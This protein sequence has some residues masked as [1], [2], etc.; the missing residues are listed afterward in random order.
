MTR[1]LSFVF[2]GLNERVG[3]ATWGQRHIWPVLDRHPGDRRRFVMRRVWAVPTGA[4]AALVV[5]ALRTLVCRHE[6]LRTMIT[7]QDG[8]LVQHVRA[9]G[10]FEILVEE[11][12]GAWT[13]RDVTA[14]TDLIAKEEFSLDKEYPVRFLILT[15]RDAPQWVVVGASHMAV[16]GDACDILEREF[17]DLVQR[18]GGDAEADGAVTQT[19]LSRADSEQSDM[20]SKWNDRSLAYW[21]K[22]LEEF[23]DELFP[24][25]EPDENSWPDRG[26]RF[27]MLAAHAVGAGEE[28]DRKARKLRTSASNVCMAALVRSLARHSG[29][30][31]FPLGVTYSNRYLPQAEGYVGTLAQQGIIGVPD[32]LGKTFPRLSAEL[33]TSLMNGHRHAYYDQSDVDTLIART[34]ADG[35]Y[36]GYGPVAHF[37][38]FRMEQKLGKIH[39]AAVEQSSHGITL[40]ETGSLD[41]SPSRFGVY[42]GSDGTDLAVRLFVDTDAVP[43][44][45]AKKLVKDLLIEVQSSDLG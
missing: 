29:L 19:P 28:A 38:N 2:E 12:A 14:A 40:A 26:D 45:T 18:P 6:A 20:G 44:D 23:P 3:P 27:L 15:S 17:R 41:Y 5:A 7:H 16:D 9:E 33:W 11:Q 39:G 32:A 1:T 21:Q 25:R 43:F 13:E 22:V 24:R 34:C 36:V 37:V 42:L 31:S 8:N 4:D 35:R 30:D 10:G